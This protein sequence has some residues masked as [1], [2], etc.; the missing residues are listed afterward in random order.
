[1]SAVLLEETVTKRQNRSLDQKTEQWVLLEELVKLIET[2]TV[3]LR[4]EFNVSCSCVYP[5]IHGLLS[6]LD[7]NDERLASIR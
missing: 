2:A 4:M 3:F 1:M 5:I 7:P 6:N